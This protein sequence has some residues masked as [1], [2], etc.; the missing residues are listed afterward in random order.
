MMDLVKAPMGIAGHDLL[1]PLPW[2]GVGRVD[3][4]LAKSYDCHN[5]PTAYEL[6]IVD[7]A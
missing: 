4:G 6:D 3:R 1:G 7:H 5:V 2:R